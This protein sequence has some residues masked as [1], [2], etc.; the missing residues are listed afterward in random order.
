MD[1]ISKPCILKHSFELENFPYCGSAKPL[2]T[3]VC[4]YNYAI[5]DNIWVVGNSYENTIL[6][7]L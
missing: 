5:L 6:Y 7:T 3:Y 2:G 4:N 1:V